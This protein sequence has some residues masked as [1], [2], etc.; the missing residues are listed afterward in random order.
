MAI[1]VCIDCNEY[2]NQYPLTEALFNW[3]T[4]AKN[5][6]KLHWAIELQWLL[7]FDE[8]DGKRHCKTPS[9]FTEKLFQRVHYCTYTKRY[10]T[11]TCTPNGLKNASMKLRNRQK[12]CFNLYARQSTL[13]P[14]SPPSPLPP[15]NLQSLHFTI[16]L[17]CTVYKNEW[18]T[19]K[20]AMKK[21][22][23]IF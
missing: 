17:V 14:P 19:Q 12:P 16:P 23:L 20:S 13:L 7:A 3:R 4:L 21:E 5:D 10:I 9:G 22:S 2:I 18:P 8:S 1:S 6:R 11:S 15:M